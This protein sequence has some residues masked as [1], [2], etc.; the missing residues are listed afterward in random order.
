MESFT[1][2]PTSRP[3]CNLLATWILN[4]EGQAD[5]EHRHRCLVRWLIKKRIQNRDD[6]HIWL[7][8]YSDDR[9][10]HQ[11]GW[12]ELHP[13]SRLEDDVRDQWTKGNQG[14]EGEWK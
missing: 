7:N 14:T 3:R 12:K 5:D 2:L 8:G 11:K 6:A 9:G 13:K 10:R 1:P 4:E